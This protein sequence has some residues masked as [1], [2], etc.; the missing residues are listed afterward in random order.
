MEKGL[1]FLVVVE[2]KHPAVFHAAEANG[3][4]LLFLTF[5]ERTVVESQFLVVLNVSD[6]I[7]GDL[8][9]PATDH[10]NRPAIRIAAMGESAGEIPVDDGVDYEDLSPIG[11]FFVFF[12]ENVV[13]VDVV[14]V[15][16]LLELLVFVFLDLV[17][18]LL[19]DLLLDAPIPAGIDFS[20]VGGD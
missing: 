11:L 17:E 4:P 18:E 3:I 10:W 15:F 2:E 19:D 20:E 8:V 12:D 1:V 14:V 9:L 7:E 13:E 6:C 16:E 5:S